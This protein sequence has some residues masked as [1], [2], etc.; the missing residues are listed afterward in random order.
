MTGSATQLPLWTATQDSPNDGRPPSDSLSA[1]DGI[2][3]GT[4]PWGPSGATMAAGSYHRL[5]GAR[6]QLSLRSSATGS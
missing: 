1:T 6:E 3:R 4:N 2:S 5:R